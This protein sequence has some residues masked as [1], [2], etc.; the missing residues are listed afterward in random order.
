MYLYTENPLNFAF[1]KDFNDI[2]TDNPRFGILGVP[3]DSTTTYQPGTRFGP[4]FV[5]EASYNFEKYNLISDKGLNASFCDIGNLEVVPGNLD[6][7]YH[8]L[9]SVISSMTEDGLIPL[10][11]GGEHSLSYGVFNA[12]K[13]QN[14]TILHFDAHMDLRDDYM[15]EKYSHAT[16]MRRICEKNPQKI[17]QMGIRSASQ[18]EI[19]F[20]QNNNIDYYP[21]NEIKKNLN[22]IGNK[23]NQLKGPIYVSVDMDVLD[24]A[25]APSVGTPTPNGINPN[26]LEYLISKIKGKDI[27]G[28]DV[29]EVASTSIGDITSINA[30]KTILDFL[31]LY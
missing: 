28:F 18:D 16:V 29:V 7:T 17:I 30:A 8:H 4:F 20:A 3:F 25:F 10:T 2:F 9:E 27:I 26:E 19:H 14:A 24:P 13:K 11:I 12:L 6:K 1:S 5:R 21:P 31:F 15:G 23:I 22:E